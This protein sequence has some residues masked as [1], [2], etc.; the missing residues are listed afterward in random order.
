MECGI[1]GKVMQRLEKEARVQR[2][3]RIRQ[4]RVTGEVIHEE[5]SLP[6]EGTETGGREMRGDREGEVREENG[7]RYVEGGD[8]K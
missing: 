2:E 6:R 1:N 7:L 8:M 4:A 5:S 3:R